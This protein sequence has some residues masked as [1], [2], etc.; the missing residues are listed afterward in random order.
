MPTRKYKIALTL[1]FLPRALT[2]VIVG[3]SNAWAPAR[4]WAAASTGGMRGGTRAS[5]GMDDAHV[6]LKIDVKT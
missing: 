3:L 4:V 6:G 1:S 2:Q 5:H